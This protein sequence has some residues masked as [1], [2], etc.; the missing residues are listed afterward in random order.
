MTIPNLQNKVIN[1]RLI[2]NPTI[3]WK[4]PILYTDS[5]YESLKFKFNGASKIKRNFS[6]C[7]Q[8]MFVLTMLYGKNWGNFLI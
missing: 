1:T 3:V 5:C 8:G 4:E 6:Q 7:Y 2:I